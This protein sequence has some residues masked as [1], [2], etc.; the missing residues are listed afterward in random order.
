MSYYSLENILKYDA[1]YNMVI[2]ERSNGKTYAGL[3]HALEVFYRSGYR[4]QF[5]L[6]RR[7]KEDIKGKR[8]E[9]LFSPLN[10][11]EVYNITR[12]EFNYCIYYNGKYYLANYDADLEKF[13]RMDIPVGFTFALSEMEH[14]KSTSYPN[15]TTIIFDEFLTRRYYLPDEFILFINTLSTI[16]RQRNN[17][18]IFMF[19]NTVNRFCP[20]FKEMGLKHVPNMEQG[21]IDLYR[22]A[23]NLTI[24]VEYASTSQETKKKSN[25]YFAFDDSS[26]TQMIINGKWE[27]AIYPHLTINYN[28]KDVLLDYFIEFNEQYLHCEIVQKGDALFTYVHEKTTPIKDD[29]ND[30]IYSLTYSERPNIH[31]KLLSR[32]TKFES[33]IA[34]FYVTDKVFFQNNECGEIVRNYLRQSVLNNFNT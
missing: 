31:R 16:I 18:K 27:V 25:K 20:Y 6:I 24:A 23:E 30:I 22:F 7:M 8:A 15:V 33:K 2:G 1:D 29:D 28:R 32:A 10:D 11:G 4:E 19:G 5:A 9:T 26:A 3:K 12:G 34:Q 17:V 21:T 14:D 13:T